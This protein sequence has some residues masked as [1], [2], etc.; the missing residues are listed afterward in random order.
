MGKMVQALIPFLCER[1]RRQ[2]HLPL[3]VLRQCHCCSHETTVVRKHACAG[4][5]AGPS[6]AEEFILVEMERALMRTYD[7]TEDE[8]LFDALQRLLAY[9]QARGYLGTLAVADR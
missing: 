7:A 4:D 2:L 9:H 6:R 8:R 3:K 5:L 1:T